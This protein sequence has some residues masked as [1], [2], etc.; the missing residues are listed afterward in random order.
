MICADIAQFKQTGQ[1]A[2]PLNF[3]AAGNP[4]NKLAKLY[5]FICNDDYR[6]YVSSIV[7]WLS[8]DFENEGLDIKLW[9]VNYNLSTDG[10]LKV[11]ITATS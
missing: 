3:S 4:N 8:S 2:Q 5:G 7:Q 10:R 11:E 1:I 6:Q 9:F